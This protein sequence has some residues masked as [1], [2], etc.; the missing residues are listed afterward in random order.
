MSGELF[1]QSQNPKKENKIQGDDFAWRQ[2][3]KLGEMIG[4][5][6]HHEEPWITKEYNRYS[7]ILLP[8]MHREIRKK[9]AESIN[10]QMTKL[11]SENSCTKEGCGGRLVQTRSGAKTCICVKCNSQYKAR[12]YK[13]K[14]NG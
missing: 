10:T 4:D 5:G 2:F 1:N 14:N 7:K 12:T 9:R 8:D 6:L 11:L 3:A 13:K